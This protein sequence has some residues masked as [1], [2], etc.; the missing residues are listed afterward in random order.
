MTLAFKHLSPE[1]GSIPHP[2]LRTLSENIYLETGAGIGKQIRKW[3][4]RK[5]EGETTRTFFTLSNWNRGPGF[6]PKSP[7][8]SPLEEDKKAHCIS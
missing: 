6:I 2:N 4:T 7:V 5:A 8:D 3:G 1:N